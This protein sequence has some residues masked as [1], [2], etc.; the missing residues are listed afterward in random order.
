MVCLLTTSWRFNKFVS[1]APCPHLSI[2]VTT[3]CKTKHLAHYD[4]TLMYKTNSKAQILLLL[5]RLQCLSFYIIRIFATK[6]QIVFKHCNDYCLSIVL[7]C[8]MLKRPWNRKKCCPRFKP[9]HS[10]PSQHYNSLS[11][12]YSC[13]TSDPSEQWS[14]KKSFQSPFQVSNWPFHLMASFCLSAERVHLC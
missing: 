11:S 1:S 12:S 5:L 14:K 7:F 4:L 3:I 8:W 6:I 2:F 13:P 10:P 9:S